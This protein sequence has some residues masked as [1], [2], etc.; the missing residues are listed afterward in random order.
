MLPEFTQCQCPKHG[1]YTAV[2]CPGLP[3][4]GTDCPKCIDEDY[5]RREEAKRARSLQQMRSQKLKEIVGAAGIPPRFSSRSLDDYGATEPGQR[6]ALSVCR[7]FAATWP[8]QYRKGGSLVFTGGPGTGKTHL[9]CAI[10]NEIMAQH[11]ATV[12]FGA[13]STLIRSV[14]ST[15]NKSSDR[16]ETQA[17]ADLLLP[18]LLIMD[19]IGAQTGSDHELQLLFEIINS[20]YQNLRST[21]LISNLNQEE[22]RKF[23]GHRVM[24][25]FNECGTVLA[26][27]WQSHRVCG[28]AA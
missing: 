19:E 15:Y 18:D 9:G 27:D 6:I 25:R 11:M 17:I 1:P 2:R 22:L 23:L 10:A 14:R 5:A 13:V 7:R 4:A 16:T 24:D 8:E 20:R 3:P 21:I 26:F 28:S 12:V